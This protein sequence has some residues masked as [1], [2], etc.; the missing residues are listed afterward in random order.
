MLEI[1]GPLGGIVVESRPDPRNG[2]VL[3]AKVPRGGEG[4]AAV[5]ERLE[6]WGPFERRGRRGPA[7]RVLVFGLVVASIFFVPFFL[8]DFVVHSRLLGAMVVAGFLLV[9]RSAMRG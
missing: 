2:V 1:D 7:A 5:R 8:D 6:A 9:L 4:Y 3:V